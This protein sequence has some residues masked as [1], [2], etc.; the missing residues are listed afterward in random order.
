MLKYIALLI[1]TIA[2]LVYQFFFAEG[3]TITQ[4]MPESAKPE[5]EFVAELIINKG[6]TSGFAKLQLDLPEGFTA[7]QDEN[8]GASFTFSN[9]SVKYIWMSL[10]ADKEFKIKYK[11]K[12]AAGVSGS[13]AIS[14]KFSYVADNVKQTVD[15]SAVTINIMGAENAVAAS[16]P[17]NKEPEPVVTTPEPVKTVTPTPTPTPVTTPE[18]VATSTPEPVI[19][20]AAA[21]NTEPSSVVCSRK[22]I[23]KSPNDAI[24]ELTINKGNVNGFAKLLETIPEGCTASLNEAQGA[25]F[26]F[27]EGKAKFVWVSMPTPPEFK[28]S[29]KLSISNP[30]TI[31]FVEGVFT[32]IENDE[33]KKYVIPA[34]K[35]GD[36]GSSSQ[37]VVTN[38]PVVSNPPVETPV[39]TPVV[40]ETPA[41]TTTT[42]P[43]ETNKEPVV[44]NQPSST[45]NNI[46]ATSIPAPQSNV[47]Y[48]VQIAALQN[49]VGA[50]VLANRF[51]INEKINMEM[52][53]GFT[54]YTI[55]S[56]NEYKAARDAREVAKNKGVKDAFVTAYNA[57]SRIT[58]QEALMITKQNWY[59]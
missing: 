39:S 30:S 26:T 45:N 4:K 49:A 41:V 59:R 50:N 24:V 25:S 48:K 56:H 22:I 12:V 5:T 36:A 44:S 3:I 7:T 37:P 57:G 20:P 54:K 38:T 11:V 13:K 23:S 53:G 18:P 19:E 31:Q 17:V 43:V 9:Q 46:S 47:S 21:I 40:Q 28:I 55:G 29:Y 6:S 32:Y 52:A 51:G 8:N 34:T 33:T 15:V 2:L 1:N 27:A 35:V 14:G 10:P 16:T 58:V 42:T